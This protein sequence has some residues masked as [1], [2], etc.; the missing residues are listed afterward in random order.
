MRS[1]VPQKF[2]FRQVVIPFQSSENF[3]FNFLHISS[4]LI[5]ILDRGNYSSSILIL[6][7]ILLRAFSRMYREIAKKR[8][9]F[10]SHSLWIQNSSPIA[11]FDLHNKKNT[12]ARINLFSERGQ[13]QFY[14]LNIETSHHWLIG[15]FPCSDLIC[16]TCFIIS[17]RSD[18]VDGRTFHKLID[19]FSIYTLLYLFETKT[20]KRISFTFSTPWNK[21]NI[22]QLSK[23]IFSPFFSLLPIIYLIF[24]WFF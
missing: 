5:L 22:V 7:F 15:K 13:Q 3:L 19:I 16:P 2:R 20:K 1:P 23:P 24:P 9:K 11:D 12:F 10:L 21:E 6:I 17:I 4:S 8:N 18:P 14:L